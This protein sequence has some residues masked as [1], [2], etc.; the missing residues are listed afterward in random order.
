MDADGEN[1][2]IGCGDDGERGYFASWKGNTD[3]ASRSGV[4]SRSGSS[5]VSGS[6]S[7]NHGMGDKSTNMRKSALRVVH[8]G[9]IKE[10]I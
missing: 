8:S 10:F 7:M 3:A 4:C 2:S 1:G 6:A 5:S 9:K